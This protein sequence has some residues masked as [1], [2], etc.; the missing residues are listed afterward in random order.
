MQQIITQAK[1]LAIAEINQYGVPKMEHFILANEKGQQLAEQLN[2]DKD[3]VLLGTMLMD[4]KIGQCMKEGRLAE[5]V[6]DSSSVAQE[7]LKQFN[8]APEILTKIISCIESHHG[9]DNYSCLEAEICANADCY[10]F[11]SPEGFFHG[12][13][14]FGNRF[15]N[16]NDALTQLE[17]KI[18][19]KHNIISLDICKQETEVNY[20]D[21]KRLIKEA[22]REV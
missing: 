8:L 13:L 1:E 21:F 15:A 17:N 4:L 18:E 10:R 22:R 20:H 2:A 11:L 7:F 6:Q 9:V 19:E 3:I 14:I 16:F 12:A 5:H